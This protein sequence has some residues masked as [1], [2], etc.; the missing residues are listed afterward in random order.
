VAD[1]TGVGDGAVIAGGP[2]TSDPP[3]SRWGSVEQGQ[4]EDERPDD[5]ETDRHDERPA[6]ARRLR[7]VRLGVL[8]RPLRQVRLGVLEPLRDDRCIGVRDAFENTPA[9]GHRCRRPRPGGRG[10]GRHPHAAI[11]GPKLAA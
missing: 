8:E 3:A 7:Q 5:E 11:G 1:A 10:P 4:G 6:F 2:A 9:N